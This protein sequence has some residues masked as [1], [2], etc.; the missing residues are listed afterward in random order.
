MYFYI[1]PSRVICTK[2]QEKSSLSFHCLCPNSFWEN[3]PH[4]HLLLHGSF[5]AFPNWRS[6]THFLLY[7]IGL[8]GVLSPPDVPHFLSASAIPD[9]HVHLSEHSY[10]PEFEAMLQKKK[11]PA[12]DFTNHKRHQG[13][14]D[15]IIEK[16]GKR[17]NLNWNFKR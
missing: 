2:R 11:L 3:S 16:S 1:S 5:E 7:A 6:Y 10:F 4:P 13:W 17:K 14:R 8:K 12:M 15:W 9:G